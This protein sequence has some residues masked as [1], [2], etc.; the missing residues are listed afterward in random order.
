MANTFSSGV[1]KLS[2]D[3]QGLF[4]GLDA[5][6]KRMNKF[7]QDAKNK[8][9]IKP[10]FDT[11]GLAKSIEGIKGQLQN[12]NFGQFISASL[13]KGKLDFG[14]ID[15]GSAFTGLGLV[16]G[17][18]LGAAIGATVGSIIDQ[19]FAVQRENRE[20]L[21]SARPTA[22]TTGFPETTLV[23]L[24]R[25][26]GL[27]AAEIN[28]GLEHLTRLRAEA[29]AGDPAA[30]RAFSRIGANTDED[31][32]GTDNIADLFR[33]FGAASAVER[34]IAAHELFGRGGAGLGAFLGSGVP[35]Q[36]IFSRESLALPGNGANIRAEAVALLARRAG[37]SPAVWEAARAVQATFGN[38][39]L[40]DAL[41][42]EVRSLTALRVA[43][44]PGPIDP[45]AGFRIQA[46][47][48]VNTL[49]L[50]NAQLQAT[51]G[52]GRDM[53]AQERELWE[54]RRRGASEATLAEA[55]QLARQ[56]R[57]QTMAIATNRQFENPMARFRRER[58]DLID[59]QKA[60]LIQEPEFARAMFALIDQT[61]GA[62]NIG[63]LRQSELI[64]ENS[65]AAIRASQARWQFPGAD[66]WQQRQERIMEV[67]NDLQREG[68]RIG[69]AQAAALEAM[70]VW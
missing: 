19:H 46:S 63:P 22:L 66:N 29:L 26:S 2:V 31:I 60:G 48:M 8:L 53:T 7:V 54:L 1:V 11:A 9:E 64:T 35:G 6:D 40:T 30:R 41:D 65:Q 3:N 67:G 13:V 42:Q 56:N 25:A 69:R 70:G 21:R 10:R 38:N 12:I 37:S 32:R 36:Q 27:E 44:R 24:Q 50:S 33:R 28:T 43:T 45:Q 18:P 59:Q 39:T 68:N 34:P 61:E 4:T 47:D 5:T 57:L 52:L 14:Q 51:A 62:L 23:A 17:G 20:A 55:T 58:Q 15:F 16:I 49:Q